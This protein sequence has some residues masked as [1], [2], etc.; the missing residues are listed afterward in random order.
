MLKRTHIAISLA[1]GLN[2]LPVVNNKWL[3]LPIVLI[4]SFIPDIDSRFSSI[5]KY[6]IFRIFQI[7]SEHRGI[8][9]SYTF[10]ILISFIFAFFYPIVAFPFFIG[11]SMHLLADSFT[12]RGIRPFWPL[13]T[14]SEGSITTGGKTED[15]VFW[16]F[17]FVNVFLSIFL[18]L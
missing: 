13:K 1:A 15:V 4:A 3:F 7:G 17:V 2:L 5:G 11:Y 9:H 14:V 8:L 10:C 18:F 16:V 12:V 6:K